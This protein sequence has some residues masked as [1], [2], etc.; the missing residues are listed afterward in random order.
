MKLPHPATEQIELT[1]VLAALGD[2]T[3]LAIVRALAA[4]DALPMNCGSFGHLGSK[5][6]I[7]YHLAKLRE[8]GVTSTEVVGTSRMVS[9]RRDELDR[10]F[11]GLMESV[12][13]L[14]K[15]A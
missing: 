5:T 1:N 11:P 8:A 7:S 3:R 2:E 4:N 14:E 6:N 15:Q 9:I 12:I 13:A 10:R